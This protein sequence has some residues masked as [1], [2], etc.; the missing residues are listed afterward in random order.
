M[1]SSK[2]SK[3]EKEPLNQN[4]SNNIL[5]YINSKYIIRF[6]LGY[7]K[8]KKSLELLKYNKQLQQKINL[9][10]KNHLLKS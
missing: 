1:K 3:N 10:I 7:L 6:V 9:N 4:K 5:D 2:V 8:A